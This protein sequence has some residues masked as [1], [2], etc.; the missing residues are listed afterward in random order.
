MMV[1]SY[2]KEQKKK[3]SRKSIHDFSQKIKNQEYEEAK[4][5]CRICGIEP[6][7]QYHHINE[8]GMGGGRGLG[9]Q[10]NCLGV[11]EKCHNHDNT[12]FLRQA[13]K[14]LERRIE[15]SFGSEHRIF[16]CPDVIDTLKMSGDEFYNQLYKGFLKEFFP[17]C[18]KINDIK[19]W[20]GV[21]D[22]VIEGALE[23]MG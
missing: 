8:K 20:L 7:T 15:E 4:G 5:V 18:I 21:W 3:V 11:G 19:R 2:P 14:I 22:D 13:N 23:E 16:S 17:G 12:E 6:I 9:I 1:E 10:I